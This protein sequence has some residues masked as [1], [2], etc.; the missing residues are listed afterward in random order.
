MNNQHYYSSMQLIIMMNND[1][2]DLMTNH[3][4]YNSRKKSI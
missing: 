2:V 1:K 4:N 3:D